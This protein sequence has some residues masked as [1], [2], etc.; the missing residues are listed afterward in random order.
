MVH[1]ERQC[2]SDHFETSLV[3][4][5][6][7]HPQTLLPTAK[8]ITFL[9][10]DWWIKRFTFFLKCK[11][12]WI[13]LVDNLDIVIPRVICLRTRTRHR[14]RLLMCYRIYPFCYSCLCVADAS[15]HVIEILLNLR[16]LILNIFE[17]SNWVCES[18]RWSFV[19]FIYSMYKCLSRL[20]NFLVFLFWLY[21]RTLLMLA[22]SASIGES[23]VFNGRH[24]HFI[25]FPLFYQFQAVGFL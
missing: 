4:H 13:L 22:N 16:E 1:L 17:A 24:L 23:I 10:V 6:C 11:Q 21:A 14:Y 25:T 15:F 5:L 12:N 18:H 7:R 19:L 8:W 2:A 20:F 9:Q 3:M